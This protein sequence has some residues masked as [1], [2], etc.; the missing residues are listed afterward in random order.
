MM[1][2]RFIGITQ[3]TIPNR[4]PDIKCLIIKQSKINHIH[5]HRRPSS[6]KGSLAS[7]ADSPCFFKAGK[8]V[9]HPSRSQYDQV[10]AH[11]S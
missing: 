2:N 11:E 6:T 5:R 1:A 9:A 4:L 7:K 3:I 10:D 8:V